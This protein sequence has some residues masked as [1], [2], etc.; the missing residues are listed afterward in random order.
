VSTV[1]ELLPLGPREEPLA[2]QPVPRIEIK[3]LEVEGP[4]G[5]FAVE[6]LERGFGITLGT[7]LRRVLLSSIPGAS[8]TWI[9]I[10]LKE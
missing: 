6:P 4:Y 7:P 1:V 3:V 10:I 5:K 2:E 9:R 8:V